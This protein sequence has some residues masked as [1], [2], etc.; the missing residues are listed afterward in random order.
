MQFSKHSRFVKAAFAAVTFASLLSGSAR[1]E[2]AAGKFVL[3]HPVRWGAA[4]LAPGEYTYRLEH[5]AQELLVIRAASGAPGFI[6]LC[7]SVSSTTPGTP[8]SL[9][10]SLPRRGPKLRARRVPARWPR[11]RTLSSTAHAGAAKPGCSRARLARGSA[12]SA[13]KTLGGK[14]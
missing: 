11:S 10:S 12:C 3:T 13:I 7:T 2:D 1:A 8:N 4:V 14:R 6:V 9:T 5:K